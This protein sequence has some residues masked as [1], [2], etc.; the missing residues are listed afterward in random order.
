[1]WGKKYQE[2]RRKMKKRG[3][4]MCACRDV[5]V[6]CGVGESEEDVCAW[7]DVPVTAT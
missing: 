7:R 6:T 5:L 4:D 1:M 3:E 2:N